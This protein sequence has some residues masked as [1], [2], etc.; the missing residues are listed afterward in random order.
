M[1]EF[2]IN[3]HTYKIGKL[4]ALTQFHVARRIAPVVSG[5]GIFIEV[6]KADPLAAIGPVAEAIG[7]MT[8]ADSEYVIYTCLGAVQRKQ[9]GVNLGWGPVTSSG[10]LMYDDIDLPVM[11]QLVFH[12]LQVNLAGFLNALPGSPQGG[13]PAP[14]PG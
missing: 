6:A 12:V 11:L 5:L 2:T 8:D 3:G 7:K 1:T 4:N 14:L 10:G 13:A 9:P